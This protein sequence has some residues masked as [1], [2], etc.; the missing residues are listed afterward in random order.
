[1]AAELAAITSIRQNLASGSRYGQIFCGIALLLVSFNAT[2]IIVGTTTIKINEIAI[3]LMSIAIFVPKKIERVTGTI[4]G[5][6]KVSRRIKERPNALSPLK[7]AAQIKPETAVGPVKRR[8]KPATTSGLLKKTEDEKRAAVGINM[9]LEKKKSRMGMGLLTAIPNSTAVSLREP[10]KVITA[11]SKTTW[12]R[13]GKKTFGRN[14]PSATDSGVK[15][16]IKRSM[17][18]FSFKKNTF[19][20][21]EDGI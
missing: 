16:G 11:N 4:R 20:P 2:P 12:G 15:M 19:I 13:R 3:P 7:I 6:S 5:A 21:C 17:K 10:E 9:W 8:I 18:L 14:K 1:M